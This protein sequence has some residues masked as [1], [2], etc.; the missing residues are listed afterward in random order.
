[1]LKARNLSLDQIPASPGT[2]VTVSG[3]EYSAAKKV[4]VYFQDHSN[5]VV[6]TV[7]NAG[8]FFS[9]LLTLPRKYVDGPSY[10]YV[11]SDKGTTKAQVNFVQPSLTYVPSSNSSGA[12]PNS[13]SP[14]M[15]Y[16]GSGF[17]PNEPVSFTFNSETEAAKIG[18]LQTDNQGKFTLPLRRPNAPFR[19]LVKLTVTDH[20][21]QQVSVAVLLNPQITLL[22]PTTGPVG[23]P[24]HITGAGFG[25]TEIVTL[26]L[27]G[28][29]VRRIR[30]KNGAFDTTFSVPSSATI[31]PSLNNVTAVGQ[32]SGASASA[33]FQVLPFL[34][35]LDRFVLLNKVVRAMGSQFTPNGPVQ[36]ILFNPSTSTSSMG[37]PLA[38]INASPTGTISTRLMLPSNLPRGRL[39]II[40]A[41]DQT[42]GLN[43]PAPIFVR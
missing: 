36:I 31:S 14:S 28:K 25:Q 20:M 37:T 27:Q 10:V 7:T 30:T 16:Q 38:N 29:A 34:H 39:Y 41:I 2:T 8:G 5:G 4:E 9:V 3:F 33:S 18:T 32:K 19:S 26:S 40:M 22:Q 43:A 23:T 1:M 15:S 42:S 6:H 12:Y 11:V 17:I 13:R 21:H 35:I 24:V